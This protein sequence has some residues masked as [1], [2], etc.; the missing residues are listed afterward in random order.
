MLQKH[1]T[2]VKEHWNSHYIRKSRFDTVA[3]RP[4]ELYFLPESSGAQNYAMHVTDV[5]Y[6]DMTNYCHECEEQNI[7]QEYFQTVSEE[8]GLSLPTSW[9]QALTMCNNLC[10]IAKD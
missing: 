2:T 1:L 4:N 5:K 10:E 7:V 3:G 9:Q 8:L 6:E